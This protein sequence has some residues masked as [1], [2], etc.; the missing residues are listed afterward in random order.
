MTT[1]SATDFD[2]LVRSGRLAVIG[3]LAPG[4]AHELNNPLFG[5]LGLLELALREVEPGSKLESRLRLAHD[6]ALGMK[7]TVR[8][9]VE[10]VRED[11]QERGAVDLGELVRET[12]AL[13][14]RVSAKRGVEL[15]VT[16]SGPAVVEG[17]PARLRQ[18]V[19]ALLVDA[20]SAATDGA[21][22]EV[23]VE[24]AQVAVA[25]PG[26]SDALLEPL[27]LRAARAIAEA[28]GGA[29]VAGDG[30]LTLSLGAG[31]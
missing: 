5:I 27:E 8:A 9:L 18:A 22:V 4:L 16:A 23:L 3:A 24:G 26:A 11:A 30:R 6:A 12:A 14:E 2:E 19:L 25:R 29:L 20:R 7:E 21:T 1:T 13:F 31:A 17:T 15:R 10:L 28:H